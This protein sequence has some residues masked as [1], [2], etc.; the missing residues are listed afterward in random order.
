MEFSPLIEDTLDTVPRLLNSYVNIAF[1][2]GGKYSGD[3]VVTEHLWL[4]S[5]KHTGL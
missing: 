2:G 5:T 1:G 4:A 3:T